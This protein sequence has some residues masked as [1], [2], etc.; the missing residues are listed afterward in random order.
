MLKPDQ[1][2]SLLAPELDDTPTDLRDRVGRAIYEKPG[3]DADW[4]SL[5]EER[6]EPW[7]KDADRVIPLIAADYAAIVAEK[8]RAQEA[9][10]LLGAMVAAL[11][12]KANEIACR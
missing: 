10:Q 8:L 4:S 3:T 2:P 11:E 5:S 9:C 1:E 6:R 7:R 12:R